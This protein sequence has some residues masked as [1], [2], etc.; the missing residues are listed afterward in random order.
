V[1]LLRRIDDILAKFESFLLILSLSIMV[2]VSFLQIILRNFFST[3]IIWG[4]V[5]LRHLVLWVAFLGASLATREERHI[6]IDVLSQILSPAAKRWVKMT[7]N[8]FA[9]TVSVFLTRAALVFILDEKQAGSTTFLNLP[10]WTV[11]SIIGFG[12]AVISFRFL[13]KALEGLSSAKE[14]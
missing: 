12:F 7:T 5:F 14:N 8:L 9:A 4:D 2:L 3:G 11:V 10:L 6:N 13:L 1:R